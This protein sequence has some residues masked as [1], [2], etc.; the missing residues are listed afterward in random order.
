MPSL[1]ISGLALFCL[2]APLLLLWLALIT[3]RALRRARPSA[4]HGRLASW[5]HPWPGPLGR[6]LDIV[7]NSR[8]ARALGELLPPV[9]FRSDITN[10]IYVN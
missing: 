6:L 1:E 7:A 3:E 4:D 5:R 8:L 2:L 9:A 10:V